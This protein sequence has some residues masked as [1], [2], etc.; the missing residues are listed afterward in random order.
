M[1]SEFVIKGENDEVVTSFDGQ[2]NATISGTLYANNIESDKIKA[3]EDLLNE[4]ENNQALLAQTSNWNTDT[5]TTSGELIAYSLQTTELFVT[6]QSVMSNLFISDSLTADTL[7]SL[8]SPLAIQSLALNPLE[9]MAGKIKIDTDGNVYFSGN[10]EIAGDLI[11]SNIVVASNS[12]VSGE[13]EPTPEALNNEITTNSIA[14][15]AILPA[16]QLEIKINNSKLKVDSLIYVTPVSSTENKVLY[17]KSKDVGK[18][19][20]GFNE[21]PLDTDV[22]FNWWIIELKNDII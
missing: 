5:A 1:A 16:G 18:F 4:V 7:N 21:P 3:I 8:D 6:G 19:T 11:V 20:I 15:K 10:V 2:G 12:A 13:S 22:E 14:G 9:I 17:V